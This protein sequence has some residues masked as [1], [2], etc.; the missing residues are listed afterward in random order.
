M[1]HGHLHRRIQRK[2]STSRGNLDAVGA[3]SASLLH[4]NDAR[5]AGFN[6]YEVADDGAIKTIESHR[7]DAETERFRETPIPVG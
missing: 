1:L 6:V 2:L 3:T 5:M 7:L 4:E